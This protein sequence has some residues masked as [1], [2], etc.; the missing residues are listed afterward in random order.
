MVNAPWY[1]RNKD[2]HRD[3]EVNTVSSENQ[4]HAQ[5]HEER[6]H[7]HENFEAIQFLDNV[8]IFRRLQ[9]KKPSTYFQN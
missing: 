1:I 8:G 7:Q 2:L 4:R 5:K 6:L 9:I 3:L